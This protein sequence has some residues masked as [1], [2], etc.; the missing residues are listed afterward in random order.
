MLMNDCSSIRIEVESAAQFLASPGRRAAWQRALTQVPPIDR[1]FQSPAWIEHLMAAHD[2]QDLRV[3][4]IRD[5]DGRE[6]GFVP[7]RINPAPLHFEIAGRRVWRP[8][9]PVWQ[10]QDGLATGVQDGQSILRMLEAILATDLST[11]GIQ[12][13]DLSTDSP[14]WI[15]HETSAPEC[16][17]GQLIHYNI[18]GVRRR[19]FI[20]LPGSVDAYLAGLGSRT[21]KS[22][23]RRLRQFHDAGRVELLRIEHPGQVDDFLEQAATISRNSWQLHVFGM[24]I[25][26]GDRDRKVLDD[27]ARRGLLR[28]YLLRLDGH[29]C[30]F[31][32]GY[33]YEQVFYDS[34]VGYDRAYAGYSPGKVLFMLMLGDLTAHRRPEIY[35]FGEGDADYKDQLGGKSRS[36]AHVILV[37]RSLRNRSIV[38]LHAALQRV[39]WLGRSLHRL[40]IRLQNSVKVVCALHVQPV[41]E[42]ALVQDFV[43]LF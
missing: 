40:I 14:L 8:R 23:K 12:F 27:L 19:H 3:A 25:R 4:V 34:E 7:L 5:G 21:R 18:T 10:M 22:L 31:S 17:S 33:Q 24:R 2:R 39:L 11:Q 28:S 37:R 35:D 43:L 42:V 41:V 13:K 20:R 15:W 6:R 38:A 29:P 16:G 36:E 9:L 26:S 1:L 30:A 32:L